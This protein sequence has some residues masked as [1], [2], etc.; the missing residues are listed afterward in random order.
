MA[1]MTWILGSMISGQR[2]I[3]EDETLFL[4]IL[5]ESKGDLEQVLFLTKAKGG[6]TD[7]TSL[8]MVTFKHKAESSRN[9][10][11]EQKAM[12]ELG[13]ASDKLAFLEQAAE[14]NPESSKLVKDFL[15]KAY[16][17]GKAASLEKAGK[18]YFNLF[19]QDN[20]NLRK[21]A[22]KLI[23]W[24]VIARPLICRALPSTIP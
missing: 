8:L 24:K 10:E 17:G 2:I 5:E 14:K 3:N 22:G 6:I 23:A 15:S 19:P 11:H 18:L 4:E 9:V 20:E 12:A 16:E 13:S 7:D 21:I 1:G